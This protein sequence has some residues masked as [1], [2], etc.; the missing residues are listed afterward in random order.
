MKDLCSGPIA[1]PKDP[2]YHGGRDD[3]HG[4]FLM[5]LT[6]L[7]VGEVTEVLRD[8]YERFTPFFETMFGDLDM[9]FT[10]EAI[11]IIDG[12]PFPDLDTVEAVVIPGSA[13]GVYDQPDWIEPLR[14]FIRRAYDAKKPML[15]VCFGHQIIADALGGDVRKS[16]KGLGQSGATSIRSP[17]GT[18]RSKGLVTQSPL[19]PATRIRSSHRPRVPR[20]S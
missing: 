19:P 3:S 14:D 8:R 20:F 18:P 17:R 9:G 6:I 15:G 4:Y 1:F 5:K 13:A 10:F 2:R 16:E 7:H 11:P 12:A